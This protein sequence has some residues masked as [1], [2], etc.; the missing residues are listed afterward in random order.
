MSKLATRKVPGFS[1]LRTSQATSILVAAFAF[2]PSFSALSD[3]ASKNGMGNIGWM[4]PLGVDGLVIVAT[5]ASAGLRDKR[6]RYAWTLLLIGT[7]ISVSGNVTHALAEGYGFVGAVI[8]A[9][10]PLV[11]LAVSH[12]TIALSHS[13]T[14]RAAAEA[15]IV[16]AEASVTPVAVS[17]VATS[18]VR[19]S[20]DVL[21]EAVSNPASDLI[22]QLR[23]IVASQ[24]VPAAG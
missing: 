24:P 3:L 22:E 12:L 6:A 11:L 15:G 13:V 4:F 19:E 20:E 5:M 18:V 14:D 23:H 9:V 8:A 17:E 21:A 16:A 7:A 1:A 2:I 10:P